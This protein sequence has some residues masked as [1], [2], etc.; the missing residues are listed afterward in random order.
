M[1]TARGGTIGEHSSREHTTCSRAKWS[2]H[3]NWLSTVL[4][5][6]LILCDH[7]ALVFPESQTLHKPSLLKA[8]VRIPADIYEAPGSC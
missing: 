8:V 3:V 7:G 5:L 2:N 1:V 6:Q 4:A